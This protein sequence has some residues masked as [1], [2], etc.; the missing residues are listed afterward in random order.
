MK[1]EYRDGLI[2]TTIEI[3]FRN[4]SKEINNIVVD[5]GASM[6]IIS[7]DIVEDIGIF[8]EPK[9]SISSS[10]GVGGSIHNSF[11]KKI[12]F[13]KVEDKEVNDIK[14]DF[15]IIDPKGEINGLLGLDVLMELGA[16]IDLNKFEIRF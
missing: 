7:P 1:I 5:T 10:M 13:L 2:F 4:Q 6:S 8:A 14:I 16:I 9:D 11:E 12:D 15:G 3:M